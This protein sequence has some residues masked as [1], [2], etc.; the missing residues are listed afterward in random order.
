MPKCLEK[1][2]T[3]LGI[4]KIWIGLII[5]SYSI[6]SAKLFKTQEILYHILQ[7]AKSLVKPE[8]S[9]SQKSVKYTSRDF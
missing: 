8:I 1:C 9:T 3:Y 7:D 5:A 2:L 6:P 4:Q